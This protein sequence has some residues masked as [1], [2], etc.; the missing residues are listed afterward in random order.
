MP[1]TEA[2]DSLIWAVRMPSPQPRS[3]ILS[4]GWGDSQVVMVDARAG[5]KEAEVV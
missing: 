4:C 5:T 3:R 1:V 2:Q